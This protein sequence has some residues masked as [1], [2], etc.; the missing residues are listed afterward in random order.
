MCVTLQSFVVW[1]LDTEQRYGVY[2]LPASFF[3]EHPVIKQKGPLA[4]TVDGIFDATTEGGR[5]KGGNTKG[6][7]TKCGR[8]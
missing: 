4:H 5:T 7:R 2:V 6:G 3:Q 1:D 8:T